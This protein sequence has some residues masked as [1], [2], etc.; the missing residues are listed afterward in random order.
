MISTRL[1]CTLTLLAAVL[2]LPAARAQNRPAA[3]GP[4]AVSRI[5]AAFQKFWSAHSPA[6]AERIVDEILKTGVTFD[7]AWR[8]LQAGRTYSVRQTG[9]IKLSNRTKD[10]IEHYYA[11]TVPPAYDPARRYQVR[12]QLHGGCGLGG[13]GDHHAIG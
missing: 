6:E 8:R 13:G 2:N 10:G 1:C 4:A 3:S 11:V 9:V 12:F 7:E 5:E